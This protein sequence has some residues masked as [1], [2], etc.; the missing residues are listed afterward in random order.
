MSMLGELIAMPLLSLAAVL[1]PQN[2]EC[3][4]YSVFMSA[5]NFGGIV[6]N[7]LG[8]MLT[9]LLGITK[10][11][12]SNLPELI[13]IANFVSLIPL[14]FLF[15]LN[16]SYFDPQIKE[17]NVEVGVEINEKIGHME[18]DNNFHVVDN[19]REGDGYNI[20]INQSQNKNNTHKDP[21]EVELSN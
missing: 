19:T 15:C 16:K 3:T 14:P 4:S 5:I 1:S 11:D 20:N 17:S 18:V 8:S 13:L 7:L 2:L 10:N 21:R 12:Y 9:N 6:S